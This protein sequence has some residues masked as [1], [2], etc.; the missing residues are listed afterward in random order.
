MLSYLFCS[1]PFYREEPWLRAALP[2]H[3]LWDKDGE[4][5]RAEETRLFGL[6]DKIIAVGAPCRGLLTAGYGVPEDAIVVLEPTFQTAAEPPASSSAATTAGVAGFHASDADPAAAAT[7]GGV[8]PAPGSDASTE[9]PPPSFVSVG[10]LCPRKGQLA[11]IAALRAACAAHPEELGGSVLTL[12]GG[13]GGDLAY[14]GAVRAAAATA[15]TGDDDDGGG[16]GGARGAAGLRVRLA[17]SLSHAETLETVAAGDAFLLNSCLESW[18]I[19]P[20]E[21]ALRGVPVLST[22]VG[23]LRQTLPA[24]STIWV[25]SGPGQAEQEH[26]TTGGSGSASGGG[27]LASATDWEKAL[28]L[29]AHDRRRLKAGALR[30]V[31]DLARRY[32][33]TVAGSRVQAV[34]ELLRATATAGGARGRTLGASLEAPPKGSACLADA[35]DRERVRSATVTNA[36]ACV[37]ATCVSISGAGGAGVGL[38]ALVAAQLLMLVNLAPPWSPANLVTVFRSFIPPAVVWLKAGSDFGQ[39]RN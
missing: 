30:A 34:Q 3:M 9:F 33:Q 27:S 8:L 13:D 35:A 10:T 21:A 11:L 1:E 28:L 39:V 22:R 25:G 32:A 12:V 24:E 2:E 20:V 5:I 31:P 15:D 23:W 16:D 14:A 18:A 17:G 4:G 6:F 29:F 38:A 7:G 19:A 36:L 26:G 37:C